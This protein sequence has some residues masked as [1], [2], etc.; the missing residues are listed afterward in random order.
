MLFESQEGAD[1]AVDMVALGFGGAHL[2]ALDAAVLLEAAMIDLDAPGPL[3]ILA[4][5]QLA[6]RQVAGRPVCPVAV[7]GDDQ[8]DQDDAVALQVDARPGRADR[9]FAERAIARAIRVR[10]AVRLQLR[11]PAPPVAADRL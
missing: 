2:G 10:G 1:R 8:E 4:P 5:G 6:H 3:G 7:W 11:D 9:A